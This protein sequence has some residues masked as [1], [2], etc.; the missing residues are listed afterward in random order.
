[1]CVRGIDFAYFIFFIF[2]YFGNVPNGV[3]KKKI[4]KRTNNYIQ[5]MHLK[6]KIE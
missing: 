1:M 5:N 6:P 4:N 3:A 2:F